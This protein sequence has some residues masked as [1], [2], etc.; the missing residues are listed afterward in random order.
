MGH[1]DDDDDDDGEGR[2]MVS[3]TC[4]G[5]S[6]STI[7]IYIYIYIYILC[8]DHLPVTVTRWGRDSVLVIY[9]AF[10]YVRPAN[11]AYAFVCAG[12]L[13]ACRGSNPRGSYAYNMC[14]AALSGGTKS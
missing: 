9:R 6:S 8:T 14:A 10:Q 5:K 13:R 1:D 7:Y 3:F 4:T 11:L 2:H 12:H